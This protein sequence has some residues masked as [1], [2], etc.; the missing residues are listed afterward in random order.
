MKM[1][2]QPKKDREAKFTVS[3]KNGN[4]QRKKGFSC[5]KKKGRKVLSA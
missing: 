1:T 4:S 2:F 3:E 5:K